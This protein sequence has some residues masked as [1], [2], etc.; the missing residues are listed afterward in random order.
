MYCVWDLNTHMCK[1][2]LHVCR[3]V[4]VYMCMCCEV[5]LELN[6]TQDLAHKVVKYMCVK[7]IHVR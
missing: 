2:V 1:C 4:Y 7:K 5:V 3:D 6:Y